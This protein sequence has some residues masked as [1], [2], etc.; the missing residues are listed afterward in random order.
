MWLCLYGMLPFEQFT[1]Q[2]S[3]V[4]FPPRISLLLLFNLSFLKSQFSR[5]WGCYT[6]GYKYSFNDAID[7]AN[8]FWHTSH[9]S[10]VTVTSQ[11]E[12]VKPFTYYYLICPMIHHSM[13]WSMA[14]FWSTVNHNTANTPLLRC[15]Y[16]NPIAGLSYRWEAHLINCIIAITA[17]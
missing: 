15:I 17:I 2:H 6:L 1:H 4:T 11:E 14:F 13:L 12:L 10:I 5:L 7:T 3:P 9:T 16:F 8:V